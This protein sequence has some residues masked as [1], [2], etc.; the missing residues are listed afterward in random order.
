MALN[1][2]S[3]AKT[4]WNIILAIAV[5]ALTP[6]LTYRLTFNVNRP[7]IWYGLLIAIYWL[8]VLSGF[9]VSARLKLKVFTTRK[10]I[11]HHY[12]RHWFIIDIIA[13][14]PFEYLVPAASPGGITGHVLLAVRLLFL[15][16]LVK[17]PPV[18]SQVQDNLFLNPLLMRLINFSFFFSHA[19]HYMAL[20]WIL[21]GASEAFRPVFDQYLRSIYWCV[22]TV[23]TIGYGDYY[24]DHNSNLQVFYTIIVQIFGVGMYGYIIGNI[25]LI[26]A[27]LDSAKSA[28]RNKMEEINNFLRI[29]NVPKNLQKRVR[30]YFSYMWETRKN[31]SSAAILGEL[32]RSCAMD[33]LLFLNRDII[34]KV[35]FFRNADDIFIKEIIQLLEPEV[36]LPGDFIIRQGEF[37]ECMF[38]LSSGSVQ[39]IVT[40][41]VVATLHEG[42]PFGETALLLNEKRNAS[43]RALTYC[44][45]YKLSKEH[46]DL[47]RNHHP[48][49]H[50]EIQK[51]TEIH[52]SNTEKNG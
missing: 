18:L 33:I 36:Y 24:P 50:L 31:V 15:L 39:V 40:G 19:V 43:V 27:N 20:G 47:V 3:K 7:D 29:K 44:D 37:G 45:V 25:S 32:P 1:Y 14:V 11:T 6:H 4:C 49:F 30:D 12:L 22:T 41:S 26:I 28:F 10:E 42:S 52:S 5:F 35:G 2:D 21:I 13:A 51:I 23:A 38:F 17:I 48:E 9:F 46:F 16:K 34:A 8:D